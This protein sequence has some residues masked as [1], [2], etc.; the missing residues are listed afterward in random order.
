MYNDYLCKKIPKKEPFPYKEHMTTINN[1]MT[2]MKSV[3]YEHYSL[4]E[5]AFIRFYEEIMDIHQHIHHK[6]QTLEDN[7]E[8]VAFDLKHIQSSIKKK[9]KTNIMAILKEVNI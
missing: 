6:P 7:Q 3:D 1:I 9:K 4:Y 2:E 5:D 8:T